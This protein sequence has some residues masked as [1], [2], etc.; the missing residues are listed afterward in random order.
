MTRK[1]IPTDPALQ[2][3]GHYAAARRHRAAAQVFVKAGKVKPA[4]GVA[5]PATPEETGAL[6]EAEDAGSARARR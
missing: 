3:E 6:R 5:K 1:L 2:G 4:T